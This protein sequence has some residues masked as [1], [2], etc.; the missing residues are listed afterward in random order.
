MKPQYNIYE[1]VGILYI[2]KEKIETDSN[3]LNDRELKQVMLVFECI[4]HGFYNL[5]LELGEAKAK[6]VRELADKLS[7]LIVVNEIARTRY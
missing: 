7:A 3:T 1:A 5:E 2:Y 6:E 4:A